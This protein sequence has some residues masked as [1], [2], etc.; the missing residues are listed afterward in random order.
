[1]Q[2]LY[3]KAYP[4]GDFEVFSTGP[5]CGMVYA[6]ALKGF[7]YPYVGFYVNTI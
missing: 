4:H 2:G 6:S 1:M 5:F 7:L 3:N